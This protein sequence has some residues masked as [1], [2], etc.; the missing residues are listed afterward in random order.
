MSQVRKSVNLQ[1]ITLGRLDDGT[2][3][4]STKQLMF[5]VLFFSWF[6]AK[7]FAKIL[8]IYFLIFD[9]DAR[10]SGPRIHFVRLKTLVQNLL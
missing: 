2:N 5:Q 10:S 8:S 4:W 3:E 6:L 7:F 1:Y 9:R